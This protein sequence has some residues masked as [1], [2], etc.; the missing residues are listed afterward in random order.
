MSEKQSTNLGV[1]ILQLG[2]PLLVGEFHVL[3]LVQELFVAAPVHLH[4]HREFIRDLP[5]LFRF[6]Q[7]FDADTLSRARF[8]DGG[9]SVVVLFYTFA[10]EVAY[11]R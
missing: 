1:L 6:Q 2:Y 3:P 9:I 7:S 5:S 11:I 8:K 10:E 4:L